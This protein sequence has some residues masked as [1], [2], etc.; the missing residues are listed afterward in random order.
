MLVFAAHR[1]VMLQLFAAHGVGQFGGKNPGGD[2]DDR[3]TGD[4]HHRRDDLPQSGLGHDVAVADGGQGDDSPIDPFGNAGKAMLRAFDHIHQCA[5][6]RYQRADAEQEYDDFLF[7]AAQGVE[8]VMGLLQ[9]GEQFEHAKDPQHTDDPDDQQVL[10]VAVIQRKDAWNNRQQIHQ[11]VKTEGVTQRPGRAVQAHYVLDQEDQGKAPLDV[12]QGVGEVLMNVID[13]VED[14]HHQAGKDDQQQRFIEAPPGHRIGLENHHVQALAPRVV[15]VHS[16]RLGHKSAQPRL[17]LR[18]LARRTVCGRLA[19][20]ADTRTQQPAGEDERC[21]QGRQPHGSESR[22]EEDRQCDAQQRQPGLTGLLTEGEGGQCR[23]VA[24]QAE[25]CAGSLV[26]PQ[27]AEQ[28]RGATHQC[29]ERGAAIG[30]QQTG[31]D[32]HTRQGM[33]EED[34]LAQ[35]FEFGAEQ[36]KGVEFRQWRRCRMGR[37]SNAQQYPAQSHERCGVGGQK[38]LVASSLEPLLGDDRTQSAARNDQWRQ[39][40]RPVELQA[41]QEAEQDAVV[42][43]EPGLTISLG[44]AATLRGEQAGHATQEGTAEQRRSGKQDG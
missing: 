3:V 17:I 6:H 5:E 18:G 34:D 16:N 33:V 19:Q 12:R 26:Q 25:Q 41:Q 38:M 37:G 42:A 40:G 28:T 7:A 43:E 22:C 32:Q 13:A 20:Q 23:V 2:G 15:A 10:R 31:S 8:Q 35:A 29:P 36:A 4:H 14:H 30:E 39:H 24:I 21:S 11:P 44:V 9:V 27:G 1:A